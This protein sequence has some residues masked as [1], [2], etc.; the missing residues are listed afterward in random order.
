MKLAIVGASQVN[1]NLVIKMRNVIETILNQFDNPTVISGGA[2]GVDTIAVDVAKHLGLKVK[3]YKP[4]A[5]S[6]EWYKKRNQKIA[7]DCDQLYCFATELKQSKCY[8]HDNQKS[9][10]HEKTAGCYTLNIVK[11]LDKPTALIIIKGDP[12]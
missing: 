12:K 3:E 4:K 11:G 9:M 5:E 7:D 2:K 8:H 10:N 6:W 1:P